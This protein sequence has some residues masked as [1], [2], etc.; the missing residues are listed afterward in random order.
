MPFPRPSNLMR[1]APLIALAALASCAGPRLYDTTMLGSVDVVDMTD[2]MVVSL[3]ESSALE[4]RDAASEPWVITMDRVSN[5]TEH[6]MSPGERWGI[7]NRLRALLMQTE[8]RRDR[9][10]LFVL[11][12]EAWQSLD[13]AE[14]PPP[15]RRPPTHALRA[16]F[17]SDTQSS[18]DAR[19]DAYL[20]A[21]QLVDLTSGLLVWEDA[22]EVKY[23][24]ERNAF[25]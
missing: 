3:V 23:V 24:V 8:L 6:I 13:V 16:T 14:E 12:A 4:G 18:I 15:T 25:D 7:M 5:R 11:P 1:L 20:C 10:L 22:F 19:V 9:H 17:L 2:R 21:F